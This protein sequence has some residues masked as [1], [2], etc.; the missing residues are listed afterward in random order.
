MK[1]KL[2][3]ILKNRIF[4]FVLGGL[5]FSSV[6]VYA[7]TYFPSNQVTY[8]NKASGLKATQV[9]GAI[10]E[11]Y[12]TCFPPSIIGGDGILDN[13]DIVTSGDGLY[14]DKYEDRYFYKGANPNNYII[15]NNESWRI[16]SI[17]GD[18][19]IKIMKDKSIG[20]MAWEESGGFVHTDWTLPPS[21]NKY[22][23]ETYLTKIL[24]SSAQN[25][26]VSKD[27]SIGEVIGGNRDLA[28]QINDENSV[29][30]NGKVAFVTASEYIR[31]NSNES[32]CATYYN[33]Q[34]ND[35]C[36]NT[37]WMYD[38]VYS[39]WTLSP[40]D[41]FDPD[42]LIVHFSDGQFG[43]GYPYDVDYAVRPSVYLSSNIKITEGTAT[44]ND[45]YEVE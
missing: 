39:W 1:E 8:D 17:E 43:F 2:K 11:L 6:S 33:I 21:L 32:S 41:S 19:T 23:N 44:Q 12:N 28:D 36:K 42:I 26:I 45:P 7:I 29:K 35:N 3:K 38:S 18:G 27:W 15:F 24:Y 34:R 14:K 16:V 4:I 5:I 40:L 25:Q 10:D 37:T 22:L 31:S 13:V 20:N 9:Q 30:W